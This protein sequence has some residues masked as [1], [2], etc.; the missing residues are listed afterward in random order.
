ME[1]HAKIGFNR[2]ISINDDGLALPGI[3]DNDM[4]SVGVS[5]E[6]SRRKELRSPSLFGR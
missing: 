5:G 6:S 2:P 3:T 4:G 1:R